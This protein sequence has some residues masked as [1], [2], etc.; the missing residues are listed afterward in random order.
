LS[1]GSSTSHIKSQ[2]T[3]R[4]LADSNHNGLATFFQPPSPR[5]HF[6]PILDISNQ[7]MGPSLPGRDAR[8]DS[9]YD[10][11]SFVLPSTQPLE[12]G[13]FT[14][15][16]STS[17]FQAL[18]L[19]EMDKIITVHSNSSDLTQEYS[20]VITSDRIGHLNSELLFS[21]NNF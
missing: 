13:E 12:L 15:N 1:R 18:P 17:N 11:G 5:I 4:N 3:I 9:G 14:V 21:A 10:S 6:Q 7:S 8:S 20:A 16:K 19:S 2:S